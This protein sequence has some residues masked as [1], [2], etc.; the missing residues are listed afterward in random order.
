MQNELKDWLQNPPEGC[1][2]LSCDPLTIWVV[3]IQG[4]D[5]P[6]Y[7]GHVYNLRVAFTDRYPMEP[8]E[9][10]F[11]VP[12]PIHPH[13]YSNGHICLDTLYDGSNGGWSPALTVN[14]VA[15][16]LRSMLASNDK[17]KRPPGDV[18]YCL[19]SRGKSPK[20]TTWNFDDDRV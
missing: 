1:R 11:L 8:P 13:I 7:R 12:S 14:K 19:R 15:L 16:S 5:T 2:L 6:L 20:D 18:E 17:H 4:P 9:F 3:E 10:V